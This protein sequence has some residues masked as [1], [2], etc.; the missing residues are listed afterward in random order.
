MTNPVIDEKRLIAQ[1]K[2][3]NPSFMRTIWREI[4]HDKMALG[5]LILLTIIVLAAYISPLLIDSASLTRVNFLNVWKP[6]S[7]A[8]WL[9][10][11][12]GGRD[13]FGQLM[14]GTRNSL[15]IGVAVTL[16]AGMIGL[17]Y[18]LISGYYGGAVDNIMMRILEFLMV[19][20]SLMFIIV[21]VTIVPNYNKYTFILIMSAF[22]WF[23]KARLIRSRA[24]QERELDYINAS[25]TLGTP[26][27]KIMFFEMFPN[28]SSLVIVNMTLSLAGNIGI[29]T[30]L[31]FLGFGLPAGTPSLGTLISFARNPDI[32]KNKWWSW[33]PAALL[34]LVMMLCINY[35][36]QA[37]K[38]ASDAR[39]R[40]A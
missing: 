5:S 40:L 36:G 7:A 27:W 13:V 29:E 33:L 31:T 25:K 23:A 8:N 22:Y 9:G 28:L 38:R 32:I 1:E 37:V 3:N 19:L 17:T 35:V 10:T 12:D 16:I 11:D 15:T 14:I 30:G 34:I 20:P 26:S 4:K 2:L 24:L 21:F 6:P 18:G 39:Q